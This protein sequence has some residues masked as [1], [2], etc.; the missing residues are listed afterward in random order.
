MESYSFEHHREGKGLK[1]PA[2]HLVWARA[3]E[4]VGLKFLCSG[5]LQDW[6][7]CLRHFFLFFFFL[8]VDIF[9]SKDWKVFFFLNF[10]SFS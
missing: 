6:F 1:C 3:D 2:G 10:F 9:F 5:E 8:V 4:I 7:E